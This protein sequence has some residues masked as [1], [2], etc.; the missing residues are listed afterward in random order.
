MCICSPMTGFKY[1]SVC[2]VEG[3]GCGVAEAD[4]RCLPYSHSILFIE[5][6]LYWTQ[7]SQIRLA[8]LLWGIPCFHHPVT[9]I[10]GETSQLP[11]IYVG[12]MQT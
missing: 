8:S 12:A 9:G 4:L 2:V 7:I 5:E 6:G 10:A 1:V 3:G 11:S